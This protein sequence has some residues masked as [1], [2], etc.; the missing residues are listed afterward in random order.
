MSCHQ[1]ENM[2][3]RREFLEKA[4]LGLGAGA[5]IKKTSVFMNVGIDQ[6]GI[7]FVGVIQ[8]VTVMHV[9]IN[10]GH[11]LHAILRTQ[12]IDHHTAVVEHAKAGGIVT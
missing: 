7:G 9:D 1:Y 11:T 10:I 4:G 12:R 8:S 6:I 5:R 2:H 3:S